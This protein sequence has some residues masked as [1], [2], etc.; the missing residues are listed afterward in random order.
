MIFSFVLVKTEDLLVSYGYERVREVSAPGEF[1][2]RGDIVDVWSSLSSKPVRIERFDIEI[3]QLKIFDPVSQLSGKTVDAVALGLASLNDLGDSDFQQ[4]AAYVRRRGAHVR[5]D[6]EQVERLLAHAE[7]NEPYVAWRVDHAEA[8]FIAG[9]DQWDYLSLWSGT[10][11]HDA[12][13][14]VPDRASGSL[15]PPPAASG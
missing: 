10:A 2:V 15:T 6:P 9:G 5:A 12:L 1:Q 11:L 13:R 3:E 7:A 4:L 8:V 14:R